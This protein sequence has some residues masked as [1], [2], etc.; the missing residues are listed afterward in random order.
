MGFIYKITNTTNQ[1]SYIGKTEETI[2]KRWKK[3][4]E[5]SS[6][7][8]FEK[9]PLYDAIKKYGHEVFTVE[10]LEECNN[11]NISEREIYYIDKY[12]TYSEGYNAT[13]GGDGKSL[14][15]EE[16]QKQIIEKFYELKT[17]KEVALFFKHD[18]TTISKYLKANGVDPSMFKEEKINPQFKKNQIILVELDL[19]F[20]S[21]IEAAKYLVENN[22]SKATVEST[23]VSIGRAVSGI[24]RSYLGYTWK[25][26]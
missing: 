16:E 5:D 6:R 17:V 15:T 13:T 25:K 2:E 11:S 20:E 19:T 21:V 18:K 26:V 10:L 23:R 3:H 22:I 24:R 9:R 4:I 7:L 14:I 8:V 1:K 12:N